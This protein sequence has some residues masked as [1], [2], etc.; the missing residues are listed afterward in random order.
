MS[1]AIILCYIVVGCMFAFGVYDIN[2]IEKSTEQT[3]LTVYAMMGVI[4]A[5][6]IG[7][8]WFINAEGINGIG[9]NGWNPFKWKQYEV[10]RDEAFARLMV[11]LSDPDN[12]NQGCGCSSKPK[13][14]DKN[15]FPEEII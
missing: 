15:G 14:K 9:G 13:P 8:H 7:I 10:E 3:K 6:S 2:Y 11:L 4:V 12:P 5:L 1:K